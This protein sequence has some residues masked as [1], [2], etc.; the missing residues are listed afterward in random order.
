MTAQTQTRKINGIDTQALMDLVADVKADH[1]A[2][3][4]RFNVTTAWKGAAKTETSVSGWS[5]G[6]KRI[7]KDFKINIDEPYE[8]L[9]DNS[10]PNPQEY[11]MAAMNACII[12][13]F[14][15][16]CSVQGVELE[17]LEMESEG[18]LDLRGFLGIDPKVKA[19]YDQINYTIRVKGDG[20]PEQFQKAHDA[21]KATSPN[22]F[23]MAQPVRLNTRLVVE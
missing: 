9:G 15:A 7:P 18:E 12:A 13:T 8:L 11:L 22:Y 16:T 21:V 5:L 20:T 4:A 17:S 10:Q 23:T 1:R 2:G 3:L 6:G 19:G 14:V